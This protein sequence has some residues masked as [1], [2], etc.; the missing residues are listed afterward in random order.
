MFAVILGPCR[1]QYP[2][3]VAALFESFADSVIF[4]NFVHIIFT[5]MRYKNILLIDDDDD[6][7]EIFLTAVE[8]VSDSVTCVAL[9]DANKALQKLASKDLRPDVIFLD[10]NMPIM[11]GQQFLVEIKK[12]V[13]LQNIPVI[14]FSTTSHYPTIQLT[15]ELGATDFITKP[16]RYDELVKI[17]TPYLLE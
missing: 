1:Y 15:K 5:L 8:E 9:S 2:K 11:N 12:H 3:Q 6:D 13:A 16:A 7:Q 4:Y 10:L 14:I 17:L